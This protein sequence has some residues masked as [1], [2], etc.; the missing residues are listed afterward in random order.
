MANPTQEE[1]LRRFKSMGVPTPLK[2]IDPTEFQVPV[3]NVEFAKKLAALKNGQARD[4]VEN[5]IAKEGLIKEGPAPLPVP[6]PK[7]GRNTGVNPNAPAQ[8][9]KKAPPPLA[10]FAPTPI[11]GGGSELFEAMNLANVLEKEVASPTQAQS[12]RG[13]PRH[14][15]ENSLPD[16]TGRQFTTGFRNDLLERLEKKSAM[17]EQYQEQVPAGY[18]MINEEELEVKI[19]NIS[20]QIAKKMMSKVLSEYMASKKTITESATVKKAEI[21]GKNVVKID[22]KLYNITPAK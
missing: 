17:A 16:P 22:G 11:A 1:M 10:A 7:G 19:V 18:V 15:T 13:N 14:L 21:V 9:N 8:P 3:K 12:Q 6:A 20:S 4:V 2:P 5:F